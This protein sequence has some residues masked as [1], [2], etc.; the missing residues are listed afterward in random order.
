MTARSTLFHW[1][2]FPLPTK[3][4]PCTSFCKHKYVSLCHTSIL[5]WICHIYIHFSTFSNIYSWEQEIYMVSKDP[6]SLLFQRPISHLAGAGRRMVVG[7]PAGGAALEDGSASEAAVCR[8]AGRYNKLSN[9]SPPFT[10]RW[11]DQSNHFAQTTFNERESQS[12]G[13]I[14][15]LCYA[16]TPLILMRVLLKPAFYWSSNQTI[17]TTSKPQR[18]GIRGYELLVCP[19]HS[20]TKCE[21]ETICKKLWWGWNWI[22]KVMLCNVQGT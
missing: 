11:T 12:R 6:V 16:L 20:F 14:L 15:L 21:P 7:L 10:C 22:C 19:W 2:H 3:Y 8:Q 9:E 18:V 1:T 4:K 17:M 13:S 5:Q